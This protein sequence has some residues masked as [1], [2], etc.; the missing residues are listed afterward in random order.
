MSLTPRPATGYHHPVPDLASQIARYRSFGSFWASRLLSVVA[1]NVLAVAIGWQ[2]YELTS[3]PLSLGLVGLVQFLPIAPLTLIVGQVA[4]RYD[5]RRIVA[6][7][8]AAQAL[9]SVALGLG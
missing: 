2:I 9:A 8:R 3:D 5:R 6:F 4:D 7:C 1:F